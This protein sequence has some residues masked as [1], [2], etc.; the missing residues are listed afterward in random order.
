MIFP[1]SV[2]GWVSIISVWA[3]KA[4]PGIL[5]ICVCNHGKNFQ[6]KRI[7]FIL[8]HSTPSISYFNLPAFEVF[9]Q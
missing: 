8:H 3:L 7:G 5:H 6:I 4:F 2:Q 9:A 1:Q